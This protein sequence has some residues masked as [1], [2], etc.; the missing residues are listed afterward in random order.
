MN[1]APSQG[2]DIYVETAGAGPPILFLHELASDAR[3]WRGQ[4]GALAPRFRCIAFNARGYPPSEIP[5]E[6]DAY[7]WERH[8]DDVGAVL[9]HVGIDG[10]WLV[11]WSM[12]AYTALQFA[13]RSPERVLGVVATSVGSG[14]PPAEQ[15]A[16]RASMREL[17]H[18]WAHDG[19]E[20]A[21]A[22]IAA[23]VGRQALR[24][25][26]PAAWDAWLA[27]LKTHAPESMARTCRNFQGL[28]PSLEDFEGPLSRLDLPV[29]LV[30]GEEDA[31]CLETTAF[32]VRTLPRARLWTVP[33]GGHSPNL[34]DPAAYNAAVAA[35]IDEAGA[36]P[37][38]G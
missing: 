19:P 4:I 18:A 17:A 8:A 34:E 33:G 9:D 21:A 29:L 38:S 20:A 32:L 12:G 13:L 31:P 27:E 30:V 36:G 22:L 11:G 7:F 37:S 35:F 2:V 28:R 10:A 3:Q 6:D 1:Y 15:A 16:F 26:N 23:G 24:R 25:R 14:S 5:T